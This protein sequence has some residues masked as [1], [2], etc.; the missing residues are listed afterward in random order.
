MLNRL[1]PKARVRVLSLL[2]C[3][4]TKS[5]YMRE[6][7]RLSGLPVRAV[8]REVAL[9]EA[10]GLCERIPRGKQ[11]FFRARTGHPLFPEL[12][13]LLLKASGRVAASP[14]TH[15]TPIASAEPQRQRS[16]VPPA[17]GRPDS[18]RVW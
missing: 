17:P 11:V 12:R 14:P 8:Q 3:D 10:V 15:P 1:L 4:P 18:W 9:Y 13:A 5:F 7:A 6:I 16:T 2:L